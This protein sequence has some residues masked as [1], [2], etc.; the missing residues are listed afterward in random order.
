MNETATAESTT[1][2]LSE[3]SQHRWRGGT[4]FRQKLSLFPSMRA[5]ES[6]RGVLDAGL[7][8]VMTPLCSLN[9]GLSQR[10]DRLAGLKAADTSVVTAI[11]LKLR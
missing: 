8:I 4:W 1:L 5:G 10:Y 2:L 6:A 3:E 7:A 11:A 9:V